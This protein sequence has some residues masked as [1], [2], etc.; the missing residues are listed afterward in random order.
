MLTAVETSLSLILV[1]P[2]TP[3]GSGARQVTGD[4]TAMVS[5]AAMGPTFG[6]LLNEMSCSDSRRRPRLPVSGGDA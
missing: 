5:S 1:V 3:N 2:D 4:R 6:S